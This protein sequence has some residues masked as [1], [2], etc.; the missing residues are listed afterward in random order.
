MKTRIHS[1]LRA[2]PFAI[3]V[4]GLFFTP[5]S[6]QATAYAASQLSF[7]SFTI[8]PSAGSV[9]L[10]TPWYLTA[11]ANADGNTAYQAGWVPPVSAQAQSAFSTAYSAPSAT[12]PPT[13]SISGFASTLS[14]VPDQ[15]QASA[16][17]DARATL[18]NAFIITGGEGSLNLTYAVTL[19]G[20][21]SVFTD[22]YGLKARTQTIF[23]LETTYGDGTQDTTAIF[24][25]DM[26]EVGPN[27]AAS[28]DFS[29]TLTSP[30][31]NCYYGTNYVVYLEVDSESQVV[32]N[33]PDT[34]CTLALLGLGIFSLL[35]YD[36]CGK[37]QRLMAS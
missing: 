9:Q 14:D 21:L 18:A 11:W 27:D 2:S 4:W 17:S 20:H 36:W 3:A 32:N 30:P 12:V 22:E 5:T 10:L 34:S 7:D 19:N 29:V 23:D 6:A 24:K 26:L 16:Y 13:L 1:L 15:V 31:L 33:I 28:L 35:A 25:D 37:R 8:T